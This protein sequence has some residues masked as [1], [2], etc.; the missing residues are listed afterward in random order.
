MY[1]GCCSEDLSP[2]NAKN[3]MQT[4][5]SLDYFIVFFAIC[6]FNT[7]INALKISAFMNIKAQKFKKSFKLV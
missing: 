5:Y 1:F 2:V 4:H 3:V 6:V 7:H